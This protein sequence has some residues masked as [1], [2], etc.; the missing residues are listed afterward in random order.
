[1]VKK[2]VTYTDLDGN[3]RS[4]ELMFHLNK[5]D[6]LRLEAKYQS[7]GG[8]YN[9]LVKITA[10]GSAEPSKMNF[11]DVLNFFEEVVQQAYGVRE[12]DSFAKD[13]ELTKKFVN[14]EAYASFLYSFGEDEGA[15]SEFLVKMFPDLGKN[16]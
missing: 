16:N 12:G 3:E 15:A 2:T 5:L 8:L 1:M 14:S 13:P 4:E 11:V 7:Q 10:D 6:I 9:Y